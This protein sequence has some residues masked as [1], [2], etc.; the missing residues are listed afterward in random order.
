[1]NVVKQWLGDLFSLFVPPLCNVCG[2][3]L[4]DGEKVLCLNCHLS[5]PRTNYHLLPDSPIHYKLVSSIPILR[6]AAYFTYVKDTPYAKLLQTSKYNSLPQIDRWLAEEFSKELIP[7]G[8]FVGI[9]LLIP[10]PM[11]RWKKANRGFNQAEEI[12]DAISITTGIP[13]GDNLVARHGHKSQTKKNMLQR[14]KNISDIFSI[15]NP[16]EL[17]NLH[18]LLIDDIITTGSTLRGCIEQIH[19]A[20]PSTK[21]SVLTLASTSR[22]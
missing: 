2:E 14:Q 16:E 19:A 20:S 21:I 13:V 3:R 4:V 22:Q 5:M 6:T 9:D 12:A 15:V 18:I 7:S 8:F 11:S 10:V 1:M 17:H